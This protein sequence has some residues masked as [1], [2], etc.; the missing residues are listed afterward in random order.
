MLLPS[1]LLLLLLRLLLLLKITATWCRACTF[2][3]QKLGKLAPQYPDVICVQFQA[4]TLPPLLGDIGAKSLPAFV[5]F[6]R[7]KQLDL[8]YI[9]E[10]ARLAAMLDRAT[11]LSN[12]S[13]R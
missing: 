7:G 6:H 11:E 2:M 8:Q 12:S 5:L 3:L 1:P 9:K 10:T 4:E 13:E